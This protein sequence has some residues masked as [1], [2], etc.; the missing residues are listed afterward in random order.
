MKGIVK[1][2]QVTGGGDVAT[3][4]GETTGQLRPLK[5]LAGG[6]LYDFDIAGNTKGRLQVSPVPAA[7]AVPQN[8]GF[9]VE[10]IDRTK[11]QL[12][13]VSVADAEASGRRKT[14]ALFGL[15]EDE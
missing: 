10:R 6:P 1:I 5:P 13:E 9:K 14:R 15:P 2:L 4:V 11:A 12:P 8:K 3:H 7:A